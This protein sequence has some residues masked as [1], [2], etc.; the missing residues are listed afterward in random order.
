MGVNSADTSLMDFKGQ[1]C[2]EVWIKSPWFPGGPQG[3]Q[4]LGPMAHE[5]R[6][7]IPQVMPHSVHMSVIMQRTQMKAIGPHPTD[8]WPSHRGWHML[9]RK[10][11]TRPQPG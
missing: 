11:W 8:I 7:A 6:G 3:L 1:V 5:A 4:A 10:K 2:N 9:C